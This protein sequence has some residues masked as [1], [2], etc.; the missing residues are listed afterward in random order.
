[1]PEFDTQPIAERD[2]EYVA[3]IMSKRWGT[4]LEWSRKETALYLA[5]DAISA[6]FCIHH[7]GN[8]VGVG[9]F[10]LH[11]EDVSTEYGPWLYLL[12]VDPEYRGYDLGI[13][14]TQ[15]RMEHA[16][17]MGYKEI[18][19]DTVDAAPY[20]KALGWEEVGTVRWEDNPILIMKWDLAK[21][22]PNSTK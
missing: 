6:G 14:L 4:S 21:E 20:H 15:K 11:N 2:I 9:L 17:K 19:L 18:Y 7:E 22:F 5:Q 16:R 3:H 12:W 8:T 13:L 10:S 1:M